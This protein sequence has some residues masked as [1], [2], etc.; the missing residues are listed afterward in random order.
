MNEYD[1]LTML[2]WLKRELRWEARQRGL[3]TADLWREM[4]GAGT[5]LEEEVD[6]EAVFV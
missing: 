6:V 5:V 2:R 1:P 4:T 3:T